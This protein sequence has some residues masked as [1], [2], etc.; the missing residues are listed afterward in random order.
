M[1][2]NPPVSRAWLPGDG[3]PRRLQRAGACL[4][5]ALAVGL[6]ACAKPAPTSFI[7]PGHEGA[8]GVE[9]VLLG[10]ANL[11]VALRAEL[12]AGVEPLQQEIVAYLETHGRQVERLAL[13]EGRRLWEESIEEAKGSGA[14]MSFQGT[15]TLFARRLSGTR[16]FQAL[17]M[18]SLLYHFVRVKHR[19]AD[20]DG[21]DRRMRV[22]NIPPRKAGRSDNWLVNILGGIGIASDAPV[23]SLHVVVLSRDGQKVFEGRGGLDFVQE[24]DLK[25][26]LK[27]YDVDV[28]VRA[29]LLQDREILREGVEIAFTPY[30]PPA[31]ER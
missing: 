7:T 26:F 6:A 5:G 8:P 28:H 12:E 25:D 1:V 19:R 17:V 21:V 4:A 15:A 16:E 31:P 29:D 23:T 10:P 9:R 11:F 3:R 24:I 2:S 22:V 13:L 14:P 27:S 18:P 20:W 30:L